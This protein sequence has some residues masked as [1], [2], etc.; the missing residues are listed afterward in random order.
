MG[1]GECVWVLGIRILLDPHLVVVVE[2]V[3]LM[4]YWAS[5]YISVKSPFVGDLFFFP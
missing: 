5:W 1:A 4:F 3:G 2:V